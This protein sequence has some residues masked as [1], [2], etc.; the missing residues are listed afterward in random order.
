MSLRCLCNLFK[1]DTQP[2]SWEKTR[3]G[4]PGGEAE[5]MRCP[6]QDPARGSW[7][8]PSSARLFLSLSYCHTISREALKSSS[9]APF[10]PASGA[11]L[12]TWTPA[13]PK[14]PWLRG[15]GAGGSPSAF[16][17]GTRRARLV[18]G[19]LGPERTSETRGG[20]GEYRDAPAMRICWSSL[21]S[22]PSLLP[23]AVLLDKFPFSR[24]RL[25][26]PTWNGG[27][28]GAQRKC[29]EGQGRSREPSR[30]PPQGAVSLLSR[31]DSG[32]L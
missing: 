12:G 8:Y 30:P 22:S 28:G 10:F 31:S 20:L 16:S 5:V 26:L 1:K 21:S 14:C 32:D 2:C 13:T 3:P 4:L 18:E 27:T 29:P 19:Q 23:F 6:L 25:P 7:R 24:P 17:L 11:S 9:P 15:S